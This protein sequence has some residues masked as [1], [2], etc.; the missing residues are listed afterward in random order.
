[1][2]NPTADPQD[3]EAVEALEASVTA[4]ALSDDPLIA[5][6]LSV[7]DAY[8]LDLRDATENQRWAIKVA[9]S[10]ER[11][12]VS[13]LRSAAYTATRSPRS[14]TLRTLPPHSPMANASLDLRTSVRLND[15]SGE[16]D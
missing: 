9:P 16:R 7:V 12:C 14:S 13:W 8:S 5:A 4:R 1:M 11:H 2:T 15:H 10:M 6:S 3:A